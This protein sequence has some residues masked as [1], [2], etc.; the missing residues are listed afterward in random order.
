MPLASV[1][2]QVEVARALQIDAPKVDAMVG[3]AHELSSKLKERRA[4]LITA[5][6]TDR[7]DIATYGK[8]G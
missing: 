8:A 2:S 6:V 7:L 1:G 4:D 3:K 5:A